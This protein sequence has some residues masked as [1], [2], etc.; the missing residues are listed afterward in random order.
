MAKIDVNVGEIKDRSPMPEGIYEGNIEDFSDILT[1]KNGGKYL[2]VKI[3]FSY[4]S[5]NYTISDNYVKLDSTRF[6]DMVRSTGHGDFISD[7]IELIGSP[8]SC[9]VAQEIYEGRTMNKIEKYIP[10]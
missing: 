9:T 10:K 3:K 4:N 5:E 6:R 8:V 7:T 1:D 2:K